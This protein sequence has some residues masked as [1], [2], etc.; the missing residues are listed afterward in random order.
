VNLYELEIVIVGDHLGYFYQY[1]GDTIADVWFQ[2]QADPI[3]P[4]NDIV[5]FRIRFLS[6]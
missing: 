3:F 6:L 2:Y 4:I 1:Y 5:E